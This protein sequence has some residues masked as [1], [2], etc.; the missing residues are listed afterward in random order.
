MWGES[1]YNVLVQQVEGCSDILTHVIAKIEPL[2]GSDAI[3]NE[4]L[5]LL[6]VT[7][8][9]LDRRA[10]VMLRLYDPAAAGMLRAGVKR[11]PRRRLFKSQAAEA[12]DLDLA[13]KPPRRRRLVSSTSDAG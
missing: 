13:E 6:R 9:Q 11:D 10:L 2:V 8:D 12:L 7:V 1:R 4:L 3:A 5:H